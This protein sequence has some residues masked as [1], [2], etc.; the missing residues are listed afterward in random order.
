MAVLTGVHRRHETDYR[1]KYVELLSKVNQVSRDD[2]DGRHLLFPTPSIMPSEAPSMSQLMTTR[3]GLP[4]AQEML[5]L[6]IDTS[7]KRPIYNVR[8]RWEFACLFGCM[9]LVRP[10]SRE[11]VMQA[12]L[13]TDFVMGTVS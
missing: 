12:W 2:V 13:L 6:A 3:P 1:Y 4:A 5:A 8:R 10:M 11:E 9:Y 7:G